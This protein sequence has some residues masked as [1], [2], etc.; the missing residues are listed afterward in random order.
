MSQSDDLKFSQES[1]SL[2]LTGGATGV[3]I[4][5][6]LPLVN[7]SFFESHMLNTAVCSNSS[8]LYLLRL[9]ITAFGAFPYKFYV[10]R[11]I[12]LVV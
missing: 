1:L 12:M 6:Q 10:T 2:L 3:S 5:N 11:E 7:L 9:Q 8:T 4:D